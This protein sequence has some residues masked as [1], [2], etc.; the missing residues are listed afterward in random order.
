MSRKDVQDMDIP[1]SQLI[2]WLRAEIRER[3]QREGIQE[4]HKLSRFPSQP[5]AN[6]S[7]NDIEQD[8]RVLVAQ[9][10]SKK[11]NRHQIRQQA[12]ARAASLV[13]SF[14]DGPIAAIETTDNVM[15]QIR[16]T[17]LSDPDSWRKVIH[18]ATMTDRKYIGEIHELLKTLA[19]ENAGITR[20]AFLYNFRTGSCVYYDLEA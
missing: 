6:A 4:R 9:T 18:S 2:P 8:V 13:S 7:T 20:N 10:R 16:C 5:D 12:Q 14:L 11:S 3:D 17:R 19:H 15:D 1:T